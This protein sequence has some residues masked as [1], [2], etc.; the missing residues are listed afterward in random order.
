M[1]I[2]LFGT[3][4]PF[5]FKLPNARGKMMARL[6]SS[7]KEI[8]ED[9]LVRSRKEKE[10]GGMTNDMAKSIIGTLSE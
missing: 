6:H 4:M 8:A 10:A 1:F 3:M 7:M 5:L 2:L 9:L